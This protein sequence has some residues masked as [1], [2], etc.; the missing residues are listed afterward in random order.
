MSAVPVIEQ[1]FANRADA[2]PAGADLKVTR[3]NATVAKGPADYFTGEVRVS[4]NHQG[5]APA[6]ISGATVSFA[7]GARTAWHTHPL[8]QTLYIVSGRGWVQKEGGPTE[9]VGPGDVV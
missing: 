9:V 7:A 8:G 3:A 4:G 2:G 1:V 6:R 5:D